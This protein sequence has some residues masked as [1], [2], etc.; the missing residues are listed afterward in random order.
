MHIEWGIIHVLSIVKVEFKSR[1]SQQVSVNTLWSKIVQRI[2]PGTHSTGIEILEFQNQN[3]RS[4]LRGCY[5]CWWAEVGQIKWCQKGFGSE[6]RLYFSPK[7][8]Y[9]ASTTKAWRLTLT[10]G[11]EE[12]I[13][14]GMRKMPGLHY[15]AGP[16]HA[17][18]KC[19]MGLAYG[20]CNFRITY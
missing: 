18:G 10:V 4:H 12:I 14:R 6:A 16:Q 9:S 3:F 7:S 15:L 8:V 5:C 13:S 20:R 11:R 19:F 1:L 2:L 17:A